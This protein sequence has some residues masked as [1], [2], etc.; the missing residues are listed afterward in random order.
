LYCAHHSPQDIAMDN[1]Q[2][3]GVDIMS[4][5]KL[6]VDR[7]IHLSGMR[8]AVSVESGIDYAATRRA[9]LK[10]DLIV[11]LTVTLLY[12]ISFV[13]KTNLGN[14]AKGGLLKDLKMSS[15]QFSVVLSIFF[16]PYLA[17]ELFSNLLFKKIGPHIFI[18]GL[19][20]LWGI[21]ETFQ[22]FVTTYQGLIVCRICLGFTE[23][24][25][26]PALVLYLSE[27]YKRHELNQRLAI[28]FSAISLAGA[29]SGLLAFTILHLDGKG[30]KPGWSWIFILEGIATI[31]IG[32]ATFFWLPKDISSAKFLTEDEKAAALAVLHE[33]MALDNVEEEFRLSS[34]WSTLR[35]PHVLILGS[36]GFFG[37]YLVFGLAYFM[38]TVVGSLGYSTTKTQLY[39]VPPF[40][41]GF[42]VSVVAAYFSDRYQCRGLAGIIA[43]LITLGGFI[44]MYESTNIHVRWWSLFVQV[45]GISICTPCQIAWIPNNVTPHYRRA[46]AVALVF[47]AGSIGGILATWMYHDTPHFYNTT[48]VN[49][50]FTVAFIINCAIG[51]A[52]LHRQ[53]LRKADERA[54]HHN[55]PDDN[56]EEKLRLGDRHRDFIY[57]L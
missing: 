42:F 4:E 19:V 48:R 15:H 46:T 34:V 39:T 45:V 9:R 41:F 52:Y 56:L 44:M 36:N 5:T 49:I 18:P 54:L 14:A 10:L 51:M 55:I 17:I 26:I 53:N 2:T 32:T 47:I 20:I 23:G 31:I 22:G 33:D 57:T 11:L 50:G 29:F 21:V 43:S 30:G 1:P 24:P 27:F 28:L 13:D 8:D 6:S 16:V 12:F 40:A 37:G 7:E 25:L 3:I 38:P 35:A